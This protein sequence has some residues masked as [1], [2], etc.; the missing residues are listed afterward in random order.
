MAATALA[1]LMALMPFPVSAAGMPAPSADWAGDFCT[2]LEGMIDAERARVRADFARSLVDVVRQVRAERRLEGPPALTPDEAVNVARRLWALWLPV[3]PAA[4]VGIDGE[5][6][7]AWLL[8][9]TAAPDPH[10]AGEPIRIDRASGEVTWTLPDPSEHE[11]LHA[12][13]CGP[14]PSG[15]TEVS[16]AGE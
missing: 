13:V 5:R 3:A 4:S 16:A 8:V 12:E 2:R 11:R 9:P 14:A 1:A 10:D 7:G 15:G 6:D